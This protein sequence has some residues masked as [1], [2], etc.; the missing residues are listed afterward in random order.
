MSQ[1]LSDSFLDDNKAQQAE[2][3]ANNVSVDNSVSAK[4]KSTLRSRR[5]TTKAEFQK[6]IIEQS[7]FVHFKN[8]V[9]TFI[10]GSDHNLYNTVTFSIF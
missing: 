9:Y 3:N 8:I 10:W 1:Y 6:L 5:R 2:Q 4:S 7:Q